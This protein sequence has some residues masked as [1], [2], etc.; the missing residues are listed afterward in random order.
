MSS[1]KP[2]G[3]ERQLIAGVV[4]KKDLTDQRMALDLATLFMVLPWLLQNSD[5]DV[6]TLVQR[7]AY[8]SKAF[9]EKGTRDA[10]I[11]GLMQNFAQAQNKRLDLKHVEQLL[12]SIKNA[13]D[14]NY[15][16]EK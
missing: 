1:N 9:V 10:L 14:Q 8:E 15:P 3:P 11:R 13:V 16:K 4:Y 6:D 5:R 12:R 7:A 2:L